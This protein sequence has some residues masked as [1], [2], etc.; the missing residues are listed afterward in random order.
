MQF[1]YSDGTR[2]GFGERKID[3]RDHVH[4]WIAFPR[5]RIESYEDIRR[6]ER[7]AGSRFA[8]YEVVFR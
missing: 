7:G 1:L 6:C 2:S 4:F 5:V 3:Q 8:I